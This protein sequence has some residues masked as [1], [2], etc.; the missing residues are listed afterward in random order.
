MMPTG[1]PIFMGV[2]GAILLIA[3]FH[4][5]DSGSVPFAVVWFSVLAAILFQALRMPT[6]IEWHGDGFISFR[7]P[8]RTLHLAASDIESVRPSANPGFFEI[9]CAGKKFRFLNQFTGFHEFL[10]RLK[11]ENPAV[12]FRGC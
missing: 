4:E 7:A 12:E 3:F 9:R 6:E 8:I 11:L 5:R 1:A 2:I 10:T